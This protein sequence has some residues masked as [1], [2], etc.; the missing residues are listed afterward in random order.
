LVGRNPPDRLISSPA[1]R[2]RQTAAPTAERL[3]QEVEIDGR[4]S[5][6]NPD[7]ESYVTLEEARARDPIAHRTRMAAY[8][9]G[10]AGFGL[11]S[12]QCRAR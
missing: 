12:R 3:G 8:R 7:L 10:E 1:L 5:D 4:L 2:A 9:E 6:A 11:D